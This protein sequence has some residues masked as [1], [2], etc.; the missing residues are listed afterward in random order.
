MKA[1]PKNWLESLKTERSTKTKVK[2]DLKLKLKLELLDDTLSKEIYNFLTENDQK[3]DIIGP[4][5]KW[6]NRIGNGKL[7]QQKIKAMFKY[8]H[9]YLKDNKLKMIKWKL[10]HYILPCKQLLHIWRISNNE[11][12]NVCD[13]VEDYNHFFIQCKY[14]EQF[15]VKIKEL[16][17][18]LNLDEHV[19]SLPH[20]V[21][22]YKI[23]DESYNE[24]NFLLTII[25]FSIHKT[26]Y[27]SN[28]KTKII[29]P[30]MI[31]KKEFRKQYET[32][33]YINKGKCLKVE[34]ISNKAANYIV[35]LQ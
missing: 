14:L 32:C 31:F 19:L 7:S 35:N 25:V 12:C 29:N 18:H 16:F 9:K 13:V 6:K 22:G 24:I 2:T 23:T 8:I 15:W 10:L 33:Q 34:A 20:L 26:Y 21:F 27:L 17:L 28:G 3:E 1:I 30:F 4:P 5:L 11:K